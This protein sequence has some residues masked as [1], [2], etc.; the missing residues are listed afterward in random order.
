LLCDEVAYYPYKTYVRVLAPI[1]RVRKGITVFASTPLEEKGNEFYEIEQNIK[2]GIWDGFVLHC[3]IWDDPDLSDQ[4]KRQIER[5][6][7]GEPTTY[8]REALAEYAAAEGK[9]FLNFNPDIHI[10]P[11]SSFKFK[12]DLPTIAGQ[13]YGFNPDPNAATFIQQQG[14]FIYIF[15]EH[16]MVKETIND[17]YHSLRI[18]KD[19]HGIGRIEEYCDPSD[20]GNIAAMNQLSVQDNRAPT[21]YKGKTTEVGYQLINQALASHSED[22]TGNKIPQ[23]Y[24][25][26]NCVE[27]ITSL[28]NLAHM[29]ANSS[30][31]S[32]ASNHRFSHL[33][34]TLKYAFNSNRLHVHDSYGKVSEIAFLNDGGPAA[35]KKYATEVRDEWSMNGFNPV[36]REWD[37]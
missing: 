12:F 14:Q 29:P 34:D 7:V 36:T 30:R 15:E 37:S 17:F 33:P 22:S 23:L 8:K 25:T 27:T 16:Q 1:T 4:E 9:V 20:P 28:M 18:K 5:T 13:D 19:S 6:Y 11:Q 2:S 31:S 21:A 3:S 32:V 26:D 10:I 24:V 35:Q